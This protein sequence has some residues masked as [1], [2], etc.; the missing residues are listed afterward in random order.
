MGNLLLRDLSI[1]WS[2]IHIALIFV[3]LFKSRYSRKKTWILAAAGIGTLMLLNCIG[4]AVLGGNIMGKI[5]LLTCSLPSLIYFWLISEDRGGRFLLTFCLADTSCLWLLAVTNLLDSFLGGGQY[6]LMLVSRLILF[7][8]LEYL[9][10]RYFRKPYMELQE[11][12]DKG[13]GIYAG[14]TMLYYVLVAVMADFPTNINE[15]PEDA[16]VLVMVLILMFFTY[17]TM[18]SALYRQLLLNKKQQSERIL[19]EQ[20]K[21]LEMQLESQQQIRRLKHDMKGHAFTLSGL[22]LQGKTQEAIGYLQNMESGLELV[23]RPLCANIYLNVVFSYYFQKFQELGNEL[24]LD[25]QVGEEALPHMELSQ[26]LSNGLENA[27]EAVRELPVEERTASVQMKYNRDYL[28]IRIRNKC[29]SGFVIEKGTIPKSS[30]KED[31]HGFG[32]S[33]IQEVARRLDGEMIVYTEQ[34]NF[35]LDVMIRTKGIS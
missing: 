35:V 17:A 4:L 25:I 27:L 30:K 7:P 19:I 26:I 1:Y 20:K 34:G 16:P 21:S 24:K 22:L 8:L 10:Y 29:R 13:W 33:T 14:M 23:L 18:F 11:T 15:R 3:M 6:V 31:G 32:L 2:L 28:I 12:V 9:I 5:F